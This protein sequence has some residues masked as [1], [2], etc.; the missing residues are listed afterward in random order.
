MSDTV[1]SFSTIESAIIEASDKA[2]QR[3]LN[4]VDESMAEPTWDGTRFHAPC[5]NYTFDGRSYAGGQYLHDPDV[6]GCGRVKAKIMVDCTIAEKLT[7]LLEAHGAGASSGKSWGVG[8]T[9]RCYLY[10]EGPA[11]VVNPIKKL[12]PA[13]GKT[14]VE[15]KA[16]VETGQTWTTTLGKLKSKLCPY[17]LEPYEPIE[18]SILRRL[19]EW[20]TADKKK[21]V[22]L[23]VGY[24]Y[25]TFVVV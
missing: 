20:M 8:D 25:R 3:M 22:H 18:D 4:L 5:D 14:L 1:I 19:Y 2:R 15:A 23:E 24:Q 10:I 21:T 13:S 16:G 7:K 11:R 6:A 17:T 12:V 9:T